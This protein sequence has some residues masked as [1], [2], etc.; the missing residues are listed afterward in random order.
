M[1]GHHNAINRKLD[2]QL[3]RGR[4]SVT[5]EKRWYHFIFVCSMPY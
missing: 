3:G 1:S 2:G 4:M 5:I